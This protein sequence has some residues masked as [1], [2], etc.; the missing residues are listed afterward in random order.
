MTPEGSDSG[1]NATE[2]ARVSALEVGS[3]GVR[4]ALREEEAGDI[5]R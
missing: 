1:E 4:K 3:G 5:S 2:R